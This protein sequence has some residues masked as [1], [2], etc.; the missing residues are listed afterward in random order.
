LSS[1]AARLPAVKNRRRENSAARKTRKSSYVESRYL[2]SIYFIL[3]ARLP[4]VILIIYDLLLE[5][6]AALFPRHFFLRLPFPHLHGELFSGFSLAQRRGCKS[7]CSYLAA[8]SS[9]SITIAQYNYKRSGMGERKTRLAGAL[10]D[11]DDERLRI[12]SGVH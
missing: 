7:H 9:R 6:S 11:R 1:S 10:G 8:I 12:R 4:Y 5:A 2:P 3:S